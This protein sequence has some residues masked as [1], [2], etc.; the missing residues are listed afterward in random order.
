MLY[1]AIME[2]NQRGYD[3]VDLLV[4]QPKGGLQCVECNLIL[5]DAVQTPDG[6]RMCEAC[7]KEIAK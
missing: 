1:S 4:E 3:V 5:K 7:Y 6:V 2:E